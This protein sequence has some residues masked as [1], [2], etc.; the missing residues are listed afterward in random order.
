M[1]TPTL[2]LRTSA[3]A[4]LAALLMLAAPAALAQSVSNTRLDTAFVQRSANGVLTAQWKTTPAGVPVSVYVSKDP[5]V[6]AS[7]GGKPVAKGTSPVRL[8]SHSDST[9]RYYFRVVPEGSGDDNDGRIVAERNLPLEG[10]SN[11]R[12]LGGYPTTSGKRT[13]WG[14]VFRSGKISDL[15]E[16]DLSLFSNIGIRMVC[17]L[18]TPSERK[19]DPDRY[20]KQNGPETLYLNVSGSTDDN[21]AADVR[22][23]FRKIASGDTTFAKAMTGSYRQMVTDGVSLYGRMLEQMLKPENRPFL[24]HCQAGQDRAGIGAALLLTALGVPRRAVVE[25][26]LLTNRYRAEP[27]EKEIQHY[28]EQFDVSV[29]TMR[30]AASFEITADLITTIFDEV[31]ETYGSTDAYMTDALGLSDRQRARLR[32]ALLVE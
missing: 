8:P 14:T 28:A 9:D 22:G 20:P 16:Q 24:F 31:N 6:N 17:D 19:R 30:E 32:D 7:G 23:L 4:C 15:T 11:F 10:A 12:D 25:D 2:P 21:M 18:R 1:R 13:K 26:Y 29:E 27:S 3:A 5:T